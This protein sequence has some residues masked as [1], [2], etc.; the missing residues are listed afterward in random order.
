MRALKIDPEARTVSEF[1]PT[2]NKDIN[3]AIGFSIMYEVE[4]IRIGSAPLDLVSDMMASERKPGFIFEGKTYHGNAVII[5][6]A[7]LPKPAP[8]PAEITPADVLP[9]LTWI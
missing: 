3:A 7:S 2:G 1:N 6:N 9:G 5:Q 8:V 4:N